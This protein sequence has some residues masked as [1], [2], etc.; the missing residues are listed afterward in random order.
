MNDFFASPFPAMAMAPDDLAAIRDRFVTAWLA[1]AEQAQQGTLTVPD[2]RRFRDPA[3]SSSPAYIFLAH[4]YVLAAQTLEALVDAVDTDDAT[5]ERLR[6]SAMQWNEAVFPG[7]FFLTN[8]QA[9]QKAL[10]TGGLSLVSGMQLL[11][12]DLGKGRLSQTDES[13]FEVGV[14]VATTPGHVVYENPLMQVIQYSPQTETVF[15]VPLVMVPPCINKFYIL[16]L[17]A[18]NSFINHAVQ[19]GFTVFLVS[20]RNPLPQDADGI[21]HA[22]WGDYLQHG[23]LDALRVASAITG[24]PQVNALGFCVGGTMLAS[25]LALAHARGLRPARS[26]TLLT[27]LL[28]FT[29]AGVLKVFVDEAHARLRDLQFQAGGLMPARELATTFSFLRPG[30]L[31]W[32]YVSSSYLLGVKPPA[33]DL[34]YWNGDG[35]NLPGP[36]F[37]WYFR[38]TYLENRLVQPG[39]VSVDGYGLDLS[40]LD[41]PAY[42]YGSRDDH[43]VPWHGAYATMDLLSGDRRFVMGASGHIAGVINPPA[44]GRRSY[45][46]ASQAT[47]NGGRP[48]VADDWFAQAT[49]HAGSWWPDWTRWLV[50]QSGDT[51]AAPGRPG[52]D[53]FS[54][55]EPAPGRY[56]RVQAV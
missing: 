49:E 42:V 35:T 8:P 15:Q 55:L 52:S 56:V 50:A 14:N 33:F 26:L 31:V 28:D 11:L 20:W 19:Q 25:A 27:T 51:L 47:P 3:W 34:L 10:E 39:A 18:D 54:P 43:I 12:D 6:F 30:E 48:P 22:T 7:N 2:D 38:N 4:Q 17:Q 29:H 37:A 24:Q 21:Q 46:T 45:W 5:R 53:A 23:V 1:L 13:A 40:T 9:Q 44:R 41:M 16:D 32:N 36:F